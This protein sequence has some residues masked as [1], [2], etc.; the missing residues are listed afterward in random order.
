MPTPHDIKVGLVGIYH[1]SNTFLAVK[2]TLQDFREGHFFVGERIREEYVDAHHEIGGMLEVLDAHPRITLM[3]LFFAEATPGG[4][5]ESSTAEKLVK[6]LLECL[7]NVGTLD[8]LMVAVHGAAVAENYSDFD[9]HWLET[10]RKQ[11]GDIPV[12]GTLDPH[13]NVSHK[14]V[15]VTDALVAYETNPHIDQ[16]DTG[17]RAARLMVEALIDQTQFSQSLRQCDLAISIDRQFTSADP[18]L[19]LYDY[20]AE[21]RAIEGVASISVLLG[22]PYADVRDMGSAFIAVSRKSKGQTE[23]LVSM[24]NSYIWSRRRDFAGKFT[25]VEEAIGKLKNAKKPVLLLDMGDN[26]GGGSPGDGTILLEALEQTDYRSFVC[27]YDPESVQQLQFSKL[28]SF[29]DITIGARTDTLHGR[30]LSR[31]IKLLRRVDGKFSESAPRHGGQV[32]YDQGLTAIVQTGNNSTVMLTSRRMVPFSLQQL[33]SFEIYPEHFEVIVAK[34]VQAPIA[35]YE[36]HCPTIIRVNTPGVT[37]ADMTK[38][39][40]TNRRKPLFPFDQ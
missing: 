19:S 1:E 23:E 11:V 9:G 16:R 22:F 12:I 24:L 18:C 26:V 21:L 8:G 4:T 32:H 35:A 36:G 7:R 29:M 37:T 17:R 5:I 2:T 30:S 14:M 13:A 20:V 33:L 31:T 25:S 3:P 40:F 10:V 27:I 28:D 15:S 6:D 34:G 38:L 39:N